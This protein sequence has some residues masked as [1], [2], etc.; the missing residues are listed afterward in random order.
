MAS[1]I[2]IRTTQKDKLFDLLKLKKVLLKDNA[3]INL[4]ALND[5][6]VKTKAIMEAEDVAYVEKMIA[7]LK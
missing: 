4:D 7:E 6:I 5:L 1:S 3:T 2:E